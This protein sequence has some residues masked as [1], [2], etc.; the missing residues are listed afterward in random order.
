[1]SDRDRIVGTGPVSRPD[2]YVCLRTGRPCGLVPIVL[3]QY[4]ML[5]GLWVRRSVVV[6]LPFEQPPRLAVWQQLRMARPWL[7]PFGPAFALW[8]LILLWEACD[9]APGS[10][11]AL[12]AGVV[13]LV[14][15][16]A[17]GTVIWFGLGRLLDTYE[18]VRLLRHDDRTGAATIRL[19]RRVAAR[20]HAGSGTSAAASIT[21]RHASSASRTARTS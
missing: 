2:G 19:S 9:I 20:L 4:M 14:A 6:S 16:A 7:V 12:A 1:M 15:T 21:V 13:T 10:P 5:P 11:A 18:D 8:S 17:S 3:N